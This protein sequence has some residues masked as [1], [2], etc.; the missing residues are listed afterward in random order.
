[1][2]GNEVAMIFQEPMTSLNPL[3]RV[4]DQIAE[5]VRLHRM[6]D[7]GKATRIALQM[8]REVEIAAPEQR[9]RAYPHQLSGGM[10]QR[11]MIA[12]ALSCGPR[13]LIADE[14]TSALDVTI[15][16]Q[17]LALIARIQSERRMSV[18]MITHDLGVVG[19]IADRVVV[20]Y[21]GEIVEQA[22]TD[23]LFERPRH[24]YTIGL[25]EARPQIGRRDSLTPID[26]TV[27]GLMENIRGCPFA[28]RCPRVMSRCRR[29]K[30]ALEA[31][32]PAHFVRCWA[33]GK[34]R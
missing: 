18:M 2:R 30:P 1:M 25:M 31:I 15:E 26:G 20:L 34:E 33:V 27:P 12:M 5:A 3:H 28:S 6:V 24:P 10:R 4:G 21:L 17:V 14:P 23:E 19:E 9:L 29:E 8:L 16:A 22:P 32:A 13:L 11:V 7:R